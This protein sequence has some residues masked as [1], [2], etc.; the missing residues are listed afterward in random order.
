MK[1]RIPS[2]G[3]EG[4]VLITPEDGSPE[5][6]ATIAMADNPTEVGTYLN[7]ATLLSD[8]VT[9]ILFNSPSGNEVPAD[10]L[11]ELA[12]ISNTIWHQ[13]AAYKTAGSYTWTAPDLFDG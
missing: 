2:T 12:M 11:K 8:K 4:R 9:A 1:D 6:H 10:A 5:F 3:Q 7:K 13:L